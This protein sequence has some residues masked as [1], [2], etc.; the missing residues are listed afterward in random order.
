MNAIGMQ[1]RKE[2]LTPLRGGIWHPAQVSELLRTAAGDDRA[3]ASRRAIELR[4]AGIQL[5][6]LGVRLATEGFRPPEG[7]LWHPPQVH[8]LLAA[9]QPES[10]A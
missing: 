9:A 2:R 1:L 5:R 7:G 8:A 3:A 4:A 6:K 10:D